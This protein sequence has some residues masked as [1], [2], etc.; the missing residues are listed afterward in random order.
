MTFL[1]TMPP[2]P[3]MDFETRRARADA[4]GEPLVAVQI[5][6]LFPDGGEVLK[7]TVAGQLK[8][9]SLGQAVKGAGLT[10]NYWQRDGRSGVSFRAAELEPV[11]PAAVQRAS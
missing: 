10:A 1:C 11:A 5:V 4:N 2:A 8:P 7:V 9:I 3:V 6:A